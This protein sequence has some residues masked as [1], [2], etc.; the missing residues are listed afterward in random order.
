MGEWDGM[1][2]MSFAGGPVHLDFEAARAPW[3]PPAPPLLFVH[4]V[5]ADTA[6]WSDWRMLLGGIFATAA[7]DLPGHGRSFRPGGPVSWS[8]DDIAGLVRDAAAATMRTAGSDRV[9]LVGESV[10]GTACLAAAAGNAA[11]AAV[12]TCSTAHV[13]GSLR[14]VR[15]WRERIAVQG[16]ASWS[17]DMLEKR[18]APGQVDA[19]RR[20]WFGAAQCASDPEAILTLAELLVGLDLTPQ[21]ARITCP[22]L[23]MHP[24][25]SPFIPLDVPVALKRGLPSAELMVLPGTRHGIACSHGA[26]CAEATRA[27]LDRRGVIGRVSPT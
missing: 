17:E 7:L 25:D 13:G 15:P 4:G 16:L 11:V 5:G 3:A 22:V 21:L 10:G 9:I 18:F 14:N 1:T 26:V 23:L 27:F 12:A 2:E 19:G 24:D 20:A 8:F 6:I